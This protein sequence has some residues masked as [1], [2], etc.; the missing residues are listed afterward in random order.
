MFSV[1]NAI[2]KKP[3]HW[4][5]GNYVVSFIKGKQNDLVLSTKVTHHTTKMLTQEVMVVLL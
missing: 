1:K 4:L 3:L 5:M 2:M